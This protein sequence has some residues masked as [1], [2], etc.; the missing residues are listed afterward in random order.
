MSLKKGYISLFIVLAFLLVVSPVLPHVVVQGSTTS[1]NNLVDRSFTWDNA[2]VY[3]AITDRFNDG[4]PDNNNSYGRPQVDA[5]GQNIGTF[6][7]GDLQGMTDK[8]NEGYFTDLGINAIWITAPYEQV[9]GWVGGGSAGDFA[10][11]AFHGYY[12]LDYTMMDQNMGTVEE[13][14]E[15]VDT[16]H[17]KGIRVVL[18]IVMNHPGYNTLADMEQYNFGYKSVSASWTPSSG[19]TWHSHHDSIN[20]NNQQAWSNWWGNW[21]RADISGYE[22]CGNNERTMC[23]A[24]LPDFRTNVTNNIGLPPLL[25][26]KWQ[27]ETSGYDDWIVPAANHLRQDIGKAPA[28]YLVN[29]LSAWVEEFGIDGFRVDT[30]KHVEMYRWQQLKDSANNALQTWRENNPDKPGANWDD[31][32]WMVGEVWGHGVNKSDYFNNGFD[33]VIN[34]TFQGE[35]SAGPAYN[36]GTMESTFSHYA[37][38]INS[39][40]DFNVLSYISQHDTRLFPRDNLINGGTYL[41]L[42]PG[43]IQIFYGDETARPFGPTGSDSHQG[44]RSSMNWDS[45]N[46]NVLAHWR[47]MGQFRNNHIA[48]GA[49]EHKQISS[50][51]GYAFSRTYNKAGQEDSVVA[52]IS[53]NGSTIVD[54]STVFANGEQVR[55]FYTGNVSEVQNGQVTFNA[56]SNGVILIEKAGEIPAT[57]SV[58]ATPPGGTFSTDSIEVTLQSN[59]VHNSYYSIDGQEPI[60]YKHG[61]TITIGDGLEHGDT[62]KL[63]LFGEHENGVTEAEYTYRKTDGLT[64]HFMK[65]DNWGQPQLYYYNTNP[66]SDETN[67]NTAPDMVEAE[68]GWYSFTID[69]VESATVI[70]KDRNGNQFPQQNQPGVEIKQESW[71]DGQWHTSKPSSLEIPDGNEVTIYY[72]GVTN[73]HIHYRPNGGSWTVAPGEKLSTSDFAGYYEITLD[74]GDADGLVAAFNNGSNQW[75]NNQGRDYTFGIGTFTVENG[76]IREGKPSSGKTATIYYQTNWS[77]PHIHFALNGGQWTDVPGVRMTNSSNYPGYHVYIVNLESSNGLSAVFNNGSG[78]WDNNQGQNYSFTEGTF[79]LANGQIKQGTP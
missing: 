16:A 49:G 21:I 20:Y 55:D 47:I 22:S 3:F 33:S 42:L 1:E 18:D 60:S 40:P 74:I 52:V 15:F 36:L 5:W 70:F 69:N 24:G 13:M 75:D 29:W 31:D 54:V 45:I 56:H 26:T 8:L 51:K 76:Q 59:H 72:Q 65:P 25:Q 71:Y 28:D 50:N 7:G 63:Q 48:I 46:E 39:D 53:A 44:T 38:R 17:S 35:G 14:R 23:L 57:P 30:A 9:H 43:G 77:N 32:F 78:Q 10:H 66:E 37:G 11:Y 58:S 41:M 68:D 4:N 67:W 19:Q 61:D 62:I 34:F 64:I 6:H 79:T 73:P 12:A 2:T 27:Q